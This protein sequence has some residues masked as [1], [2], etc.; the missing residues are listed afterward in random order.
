MFDTIRPVRLPLLLA[1]AALL[2]APAFAENN[3]R[4]DHL[5]TEL[6]KVRQV[7]ETALFLMGDSSPGSSM[8]K[9]ATARKSN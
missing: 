5:L 9:M 8:S 6:G 3:A 4:I 1:V 7:R 2:S